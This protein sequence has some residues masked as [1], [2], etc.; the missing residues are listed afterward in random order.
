[1]GKGRLHHTVIVGDRDVRSLR[2]ISIAIFRNKLL[3][4]VLERWW[5]CQV[6]EAMT[7]DFFEFDLLSD[8]EDSK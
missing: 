1:M 3:Y 4:I 8:E 2:N 5:L 6:D 7:R